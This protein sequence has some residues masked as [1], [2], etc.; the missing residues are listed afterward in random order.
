M[1]QVKKNKEFILE[2]ILAISGKSKSRELL[3]KYNHDQGL[4]THIMFFDSIFKNYEYLVDE[5]IAEGDRVMVR[6][7]LKGKHEGEFLGIPATNK[8]VEFPFVV[9]YEIKDEKIVSSWLVANN[10]VLV[11]QLKR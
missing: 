9:G 1:N 5:I 7:R 11:E 4:I 6:A 10:L 3:E 2:Y 8:E